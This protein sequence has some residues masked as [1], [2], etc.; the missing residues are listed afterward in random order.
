MKAIQ[1]AFAS[2]T[3]AL[4]LVSSHALGAPLF[5]K[6]ITALH[7]ED[8]GVYTTDWTVYPIRVEQINVSSRKPEEMILGLFEDGKEGGFQGIVQIY[9]DQPVTSFVAT[10]FSGKRQFSDV[11][12]KDMMKSEALP[13]KL[14]SNIFAL[15]CKDSPL[16]AVDVNMSRN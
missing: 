2:I 7:I 16:S 8:G 1:Y 14:V 5:P 11:S 3:C 12:L 4:A 6:A 10:G 13:R 9:C 15:F